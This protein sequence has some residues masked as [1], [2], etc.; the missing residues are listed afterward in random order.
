M[1]WFNR[2]PISDENGGS[3]Q[4]RQLGSAHIALE[5]RIYMMVLWVGA[6][7]MGMGKITLGAWLILVC[8]Y[9][10]ARP[11]GEPQSV[12]SVV[13]WGVCWLLFIA[14]LLLGRP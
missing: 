11:D 5:G 6:A 10:V 2:T 3:R 7:L 13:I 8:T 4:T 14:A 9:L 1:T 12:T